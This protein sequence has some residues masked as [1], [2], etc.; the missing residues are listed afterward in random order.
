M[1]IHIPVIYVRR[2]I[3]KQFSANLICLPVKDNDVDHYL[4][5]HQERTDGID[6][7]LQSLVFWIAV[8]AEEISGKPPT[9]SHFLS[10]GSKMSDNRIPEAPA[11]DACHPATADR[12]HGSHICRV[13]GTPL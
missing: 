1:F 3:S 12:L 6:C 10:P 13:N 11:P 8:S 4:I 2:D 9:D 7:N 5:F